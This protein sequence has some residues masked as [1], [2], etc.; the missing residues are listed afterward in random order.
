MRFVRLRRLI[1]TL[2]NIASF[3][4]AAI[5]FAFGVAIVYLSPLWGSLGLASAAA[6]V[7]VGVY[8]SNHR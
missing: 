4:C 1:R 5:G 8:L 6:L 3:I 7:L 2:W